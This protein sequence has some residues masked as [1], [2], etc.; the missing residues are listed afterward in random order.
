MAESKAIAIQRVVSIDQVTDQIEAKGIEWKTRINE[1]RELLWMI[2]M[3][4]VSLLVIILAMSIILSVF[5]ILVWYIFELEVKVCWALN[6]WLN[7]RYL[8]K[9]FWEFVI[10][11]PHHYH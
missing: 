1:W 9:D 10:S 8:V 6:D 2:L 4:T 11:I 3:G 5:I 7:N